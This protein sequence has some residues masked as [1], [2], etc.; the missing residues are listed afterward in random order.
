MLSGLRLQLFSTIPWPHNFICQHH[1][2]SDH[3][4]AQYYQVHEDRGEGHWIQLAKELHFF[5][6][7]S[8]LSRICFILL[9]LVLNHIL[10]NSSLSHNLLPHMQ[11]Q[12]SWTWPEVVMLTGSKY[13]TFSQLHELVH[14]EIFYVV[15]TEPDTFERIHKNQSTTLT[16]THGQ[17]IYRDR[18]KLWRPSSS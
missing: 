11:M 4:K 9:Q 12:L 6:D 18:K 3:R 13:S 8:L 15:L 17:R 14:M 1:S 2:A 7:W 10:I 16:Y 5:C